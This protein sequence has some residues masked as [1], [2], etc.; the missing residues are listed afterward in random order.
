MVDGGCDAALTGIEDGG[1]AEARG[2]DLKLR[3]GSRSHTSTYAFQVATNPL[4]NIQ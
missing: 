3:R 1:R 2:S 4:I